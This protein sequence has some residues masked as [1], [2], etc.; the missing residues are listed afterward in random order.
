MD[1]LNDNVNNSVVDGVKEV[2][3]TFRYLLGMHIVTY[4]MEGENLGADEAEIIYIGFAVVDPLQGKVAVVSHFLLL[5]TTTLE[6]V[7]GIYDGYVQPSDQS[8][9]N[10]DQLAQ[11]GITIEVFRPSMP[12]QKTISKLLCQLE[13]CTK[14]PNDDLLLVTVGQAPLR[15]A[16][17]P[18]ACNKGIRLD[19][20]FWRFCDLYKELKYTVN[21]SQ[22][23]SSLTDLMNMY[24]LEPT[25]G[26]FACHNATADLGNVVARLSAEALK[27]GQ[28][29]PL[30]IAGIHCFEE[31][32][33]VKAVLEHGICTKDDVIDSSTV[34]R[35]RGLPWQSS[36]QDIAQFFIGL[37]IAK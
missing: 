2:K 19:S 16:L 6:Q 20:L 31:P 34:I 26:E 12:L 30:F 10:W 22:C 28:Q 24:E 8:K 1:M 7:I 35:A 17:H 13:E 25:S 29:W 15:Q 3:Q 37:N 21:N 27:R 23:F 5:F 4:G 11:R 36:D 18:E 9:V 33:S 32:E 14:M